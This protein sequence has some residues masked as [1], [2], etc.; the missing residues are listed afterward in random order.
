MTTEAK[1]FIELS[2]EGMSCASCVRR[3]EQALLGVEGVTAARVNLATEK[4]Q[5]ETAAAATTTTAGLQPAALVAAIKAKGYDAQLIEPT[6]PNQTHGDQQRKQAHATTLK[7]QF[8]IALL[9]TAPIFVVE[10]GSHVVPWLHYA[11]L[12]LISVQTL[13]YIE[14][15][16]ATLVLLGPGRRFFSTGFKA[17]LHLGP[18]M[19]TLVALGAG[20][21]WAYS[22]V[23]TF[24]PEWLPDNARHFY[25]EAATV[26]V[27]LIL[28]G[29][30]LEARAKGRAGSAIEKL[31]GL[32]A[33]TARRQQDGQWVDTPI[34]A[35]Q[36]DDVVL[37][38]PGEKIAVDG[39][40]V[41][42]SSYVNEAMVT[43]EPMPVAKTDGDQ[44]I[45]GTINTNGSLTIKI[46]RLGSDSVLARIIH[47]VETAQTGKLPIQSMVDKVTAWFVPA[48]MLIA[49]ITFFAWFFYGPQPVIAHALINAVAV[50]IIA[51][52]CAMGLATPI[53]I[54]VA[55]GRG[56][57]LGVLFRQGEALQTLRDTRV[58]AF[59]KTGTLT[60][61]RPR[62]TDMQLV[63]KQS[64]DDVLADIAGIQ[65]Q[66]EHPIASAIVNAAKERNLTLP[67]CHEFQAIPGFGVQA[68]TEKHQ[69][70]LGSQRL[71]L[72]HGIDC[73]PFNSVVADYAGQGKTPVYIAQDDILIG[74]LAIADT[75]RDDA[76]AL[77]R[78]L[79]KAGIRTAMITGDTARAA[80]VVAQQ[81]GIDDV[82]AQT[83]PEDKVNVLTKLKA[84]YGT[85]AYVGDG[86]NDAPALAHA[87]VG[88]A[89]GTGTDV[90]MESAPVVLMGTNLHAISTALL[91][92]RATLRNISQNL[93]WAFAY[94]IALIPLAAGALYAS[95]GLLL[96][97]MIG[98]AAMA[99][100]SIFVVFNA[101]RLRKFATS[102]NAN[103]RGHNTLAASNAAEVRK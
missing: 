73:S 2:I 44:V 65:A 90:A 94:N 89:I 1:Q 31:I 98:A 24:E 29:R 23:A 49:I 9:L 54:M 25:Y 59:D 15:V 32:Q 87:D 62:L 42:G 55:T 60:H 53:S 80:N 66:S 20:S 64:Q 102:A 51:C 82:H 69:Y 7:A 26:I 21:A 68:H 75:I 47:M 92:S 76:Y 93:F 17:L 39:V 86:I 99:V 34:E 79:H 58:V 70:L 33:K 100:S 14:F 84:N 16:L 4:A 77:I 12:N 36:V 81:L 6:K 43:G 28:L 85:L 35:L 78:D 18:D 67:T 103:N 95:T 11:I 63:A 57:E 22:V 48:V 56:A 71:M 74:V 83:L 38:R 61:G 41:G 97:P 5:V 19:N 8:I 10:M 27:T 88:I 52:P 46:T 91:L 45:G 30:Y 72:K 3:V 96:S 101:L 37:A 50:L 13:G 40:V